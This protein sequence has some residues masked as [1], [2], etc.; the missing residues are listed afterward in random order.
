MFGFGKK[1]QGPEVSIHPPVA[2]TIIP[3]SEVPDPVFSKGAM[4][5]GFAVEPSE[6]TVS[7]PA[8]GEL[9]MLFPTSH[10]FG[11]KTEEGVEILVHIG[12]DTV[13]LKGEGFTA[14]AKKGD[15]V[16]VGDTIVSFE[17]TVR[18]SPEVQSM[19]V[20]VV[21]TNANDLNE[22]DLDTSADPSK[23]ALKLS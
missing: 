8:S 16:S 3:L 9:T 10:A 21:V 17:D 20:I 19:D 7:A 22:G 1:K 6:N 11:I 14:H 13:N 4:G 5:F 23:P 12:V 2:G 15:K 18:E